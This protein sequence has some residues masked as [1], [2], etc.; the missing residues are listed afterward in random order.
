MQAWLHQTDGLAD[1]EEGSDGR[2]HTALTLL[3]TSRGAP[4]ACRHS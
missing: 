2:T 1:R 3:L 4:A